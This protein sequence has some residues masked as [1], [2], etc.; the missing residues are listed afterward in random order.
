[1]NVNEFINAWTR[2]NGTGSDILRHYSDGF[3]NWSTEALNV[4]RKQNYRAY[5]D[6]IWWAV[7]RDLALERAG[8][9]CEMDGL[10]PADPSSLFH[11]SLQVHHLNYDRLGGELPE[12]LIVLCWSCHE[13][14]H[15]FPTYLESVRSFA[16]GRLAPEWWDDEEAYG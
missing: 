16:A 14:A 7:I 2:V 11:R 13:D 12:D 15:E 9:Q 5:L 8:H 3:E 4:Y 10:T 6:T 1:L